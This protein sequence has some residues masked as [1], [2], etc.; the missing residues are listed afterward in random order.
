MS[1]TQ[2]QNEE[3]TPRRGRPRVTERPEKIS[4]RLTEDVFAAM[5]ARMEAEGESQQ[6]WMRAA[7]SRC[8]KAFED[9]HDAQRSEDVRDVLRGLGDALGEDFVRGAAALFLDSIRQASGFEV[10]STT[11]RQPSLKN[12]KGKTGQTSIVVAG[13]CEAKL[14]AQADAL[15]IPRNR[16]VRRY[17]SDVALGRDIETLAKQRAALSA[18]FGGLQRAQPEDLIGMLAELS[19]S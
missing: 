19:Y 2:T 4:L 17:V 11:I 15:G 6:N 1:T 18:V 14:R 7:L 3:S 8:V 5:N 13:D 16:L 9:A 10:P 12:A